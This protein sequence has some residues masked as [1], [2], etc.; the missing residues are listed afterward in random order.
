MNVPFVQ[1]KFCT[2]RKPKL[3]LGTR[4]NVNVELDE[5][6]IACTKPTQ[7]NTEYKQ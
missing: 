3:G 7:V 6:T 2:S 5:H 4:V 1:V